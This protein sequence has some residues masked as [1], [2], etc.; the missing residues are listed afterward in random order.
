MEKTPK[1]DRLSYLAEA[2]QRL[3]DEV[4]KPKQGLK[5]FALV[6]AV[7]LLAIETARRV[8]LLSPSPAPEGE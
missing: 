7:A 4:Q 8:A 3:L 5:V 6:G 1:S 2:A